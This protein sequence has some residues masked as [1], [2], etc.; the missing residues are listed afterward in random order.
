MRSLLFKQ[1]ALFSYA[2]FECSMKTK[3]PALLTLLLPL[4][5]TLP[6]SWISDAWVWNIML[7]F[8]SP[9]EIGVYM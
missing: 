9:A 6:S 3:M 7:Y 5:H 4:D 2:C 8:V 1:T